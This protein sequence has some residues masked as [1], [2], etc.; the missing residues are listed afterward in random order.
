MNCGRSILKDFWVVVNF[1]RMYILL[2][3]ALSIYDGG[4]R[5]DLFA[6]F[7]KFTFLYFVVQADEAEVARQ[8]KLDDAKNSMKII[9]PSESSDESDDEES[10]NVNLYVSIMSS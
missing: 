8:R 7:L 4:L 2:S 9:S 10:L 5:Y 1:Y 6:M 3:L